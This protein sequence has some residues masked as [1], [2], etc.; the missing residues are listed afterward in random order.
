MDTATKR[1]RAVCET[2]DESRA[3]TGSLTA[4]AFF[5]PKPGKLKTE[6]M[7]IRNQPSAIKLLRLRR[8]LK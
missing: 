4:S 5:S 6:K 3:K 8:G 2:A 7:K 1:I